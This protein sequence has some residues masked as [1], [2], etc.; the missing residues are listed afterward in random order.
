MKK[1]LSISILF[2]AVSSAYCQFS[3]HSF[4]DSI[5]DVDDSVAKV[6]LIDTFFKQV[7][8]AGTPFIEGDTANF[9]YYGVASTVDI[10]GDFNNWGSDLW[11]CNRIG[12]TNFFYYSRTF[13]QTARLDYKFIL[14]GSNWILDPRNPRQVSG[15]YGPNSELAMPGYIQPWEIKKYEGVAQGSIKSFTLESPQVGKNF[16]IQVYLPPGYEQ[17]GGHAFSTV[18]VHDGHEYLGLGSM[19]NVLDNLLDSNKIDPLI[20]VFIRPLNRDDEYAAANRFNYAQYVAETVVPYIDANYKT[21][22]H[23]EYRLTMGASYG[24]NISG[25]ISYT[26]PDVIANSGWHSPAL[27]P[28]RGEVAEMYVNAKKNVKIYFNVGTYENLGVDWDWFTQGL[29][30]LGYEYNWDELYEGH[31]WGQ[32]RATTDDILEYF[33]PPGTTPVSIEHTRDEILLSTQNYPNPA[34]SFTFIPLLLERKGTAKLAIYNETGQLVKS[35][36]YTF[37]TPGKH[38]IELDASHFMAGAYFYTLEHESGSISGTMMV[39]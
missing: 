8:E 7:S 16:S 20:V 5:N 15:G 18:Y 35:S 33:F 25:L 2:L 38:V 29:S 3:F 31:S 22:P 32:W 30:G 19:R 11:N 14:D 23:A 27:W 36:A 28:N 37:A 39:K 12:K 9:I 13:E 4:L 34:S 10:A 6:I 24:G 21:Y 26:Y 1:F 17:A